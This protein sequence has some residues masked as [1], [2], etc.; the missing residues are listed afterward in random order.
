MDDKTKQIL[1]VVGGLVVVVIIPFGVNFLMKPQMGAVGQPDTWIAFFGSYVGSIMSGLLTLFGVRLTIQYT[2]RQN[3]I[4][5]LNTDEANIRQLNFTREENDNMLREARRESRRNKLPEMMYQL[6]EC[7]D[8]VQQ[9]LNTLEILNRQDIKIL[10]SG[11]DKETVFFHIDKDYS[12]APSFKTRQKALVSPKEIRNLAV[13]ADT[14][15]YEAFVRL[16]MKIRKAYLA[17]IEETASEI[18]E[19]RSAF[20]RTYFNEVS[21]FLGNGTDWRE[22]PLDTGDRQWLE[23]LQRRLYMRDREYLLD[24]M[25]AYSDLHRTLI[26]QLNSLSKE[27]SQ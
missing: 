22:I 2:D 24:L 16:E 1:W 18:A 25:M 7:I 6:G 23:D 20:L 26:E 17:N 13:K 11:Y 15:A 21:A 3:K 5:Q 19:F 27:F 14:P 9:Q 10:Q 8:L 12:L 4:N